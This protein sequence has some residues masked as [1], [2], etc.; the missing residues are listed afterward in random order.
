MDSSF[1]FIY[2]TE[3]EDNQHVGYSIRIVLIIFFI[4]K[5]SI[6]LYLELLFRQ[7]YFRVARSEDNCQ[8][9]FLFELFFKVHVW[10]KT[11]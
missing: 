11:F 7:S 10:I 8:R 2:K 9:S 1:F 4:H 6:K 5:I 3:T